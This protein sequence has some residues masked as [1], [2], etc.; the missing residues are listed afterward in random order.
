MVQI[1]VE[2]ILPRIF[3]AE[4]FNAV[5]AALTQFGHNTLEY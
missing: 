4:I 2:C 5:T 3:L 1:F